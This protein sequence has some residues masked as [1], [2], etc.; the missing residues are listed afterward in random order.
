MLRRHFT[1]QRMYISVAQFN[2]RQMYAL[3]RNV[4]S[5]VT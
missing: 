3:I 1:P 2:E 4:L 5:H